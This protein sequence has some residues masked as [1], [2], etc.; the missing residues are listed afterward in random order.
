MLKEFKQFALKGNVLDLAIA[1]VIGAAFGKVVSSFVADI[2]TP[3]IGKLLGNM[4]FSSLFINLSSTPVRSV[5]EA[6]A[7]GVPVVAYGLFL[8]AIFDFVIIAFALFLLVRQI[9]R[10]QPAPA[11]PVTTK[12][13]PRC[14][15]MIPVN[16]SRCPNCTSEQ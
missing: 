3:P 8:N 9:N 12:E 1:V 7:A 10:L 15:T 5:A 4:D 11:A 6:K 2:I 14:C 13:C 16:A